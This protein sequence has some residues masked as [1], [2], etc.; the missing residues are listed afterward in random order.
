MSATDEDLLSDFLRT[1]TPTIEELVSDAL[2]Q[3]RAV[4]HIGL[5]VERGLDGTIRGGCGSRRELATKLGIDAR[6]TPEQRGV[7]V[8]AMTSRDDDV[9]AVL[10]FAREDHVVVGVRRLGGAVTHGTNLR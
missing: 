8:A 2:S 4:Q 1:I 6:F 5:L 10:V 9:P 3:G 7:I